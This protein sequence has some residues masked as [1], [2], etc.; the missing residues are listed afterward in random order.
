MKRVVL[1]FVYSLI[2]FAS[3]Q[4]AAG[5]AHNGDSNVWLVRALFGLLVIVCGLLWAFKNKFTDYP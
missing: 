4:G 5:N 1:F 2:A 3:N